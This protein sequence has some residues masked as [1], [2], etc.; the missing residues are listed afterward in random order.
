MWRC[1]LPLRRCMRTPHHAPA[2]PTQFVSALN[3]REEPCGKILKESCA[4]AWDNDATLSS[5]RFLI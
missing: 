3:G 1:A 4:T 5:A 2:N